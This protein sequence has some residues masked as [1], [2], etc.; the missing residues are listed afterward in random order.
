ML[1]KLLFRGSVKFFLLFFL[2]FLLDSY[3]F[4]FLLFFLLLYSLK[5]LFLLIILLLSYFILFRFFF[6]LLL[7][8]EF[9]NLSFFFSLIN[10]ALLKNKMLFFAPPIALLQL[11]AS[12]PILFTFISIFFHHSFF[13]FAVITFHSPSFIRFLFA[14]LN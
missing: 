14:F 1:T 3:L 12:I 10:K 5:F 2:L 13:L 4:Q 9:L 11:T 7:F 6:L 8:F